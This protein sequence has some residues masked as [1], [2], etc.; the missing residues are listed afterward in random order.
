MSAQESGHYVWD[1]I[2]PFHDVGEGGRGKY[3]LCMVDMLT[4]FSFVFVT[5][6]TADND[7]LK[8]FN[9]FRLRYNGLPFK[10]SFDN[11]IC[12]K[13]SVTLDLLKKMG[14]KV[15]FRSLVLRKIN[16]FKKRR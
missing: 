13:Y 15:L 12:K 11:A 10:V 7:V 8:C 14:V 3:V 6:S 16:R 2:G 9:E 5:N 4:R 1:F